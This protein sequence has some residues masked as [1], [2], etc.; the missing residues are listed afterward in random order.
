MANVVTIKGFDKVLTR[1]NAEIVAI[2][3]RSMKG[4]IMGASIVKKDMEK[5]PPLTPRDYGNLRSSFF[6]V[7]PKSI[8]SGSTPMFKGEVAGKMRT[9]HTSTISEVRG[10][11]KAASSI[12]KIKMLMLGYSAS[13]AL[14]VHELLGMS[15]EPRWRYGPGPGK[16]RWYKPRVGAGPK[17]FEASFKRNK[18][19]ILQ[20]IRLNVQIKK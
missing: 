15:D 14:F 1:L 6:I 8:P 18:D 5:T 12:G 11:V 3:N 4:M 7:T 19:K 17:W 20:A 9:D 16:K 10:M 2:E 13:Y